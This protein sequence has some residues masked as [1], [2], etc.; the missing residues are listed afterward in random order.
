[1]KDET[2]KYVIKVLQDPTLTQTDEFKLWIQA[3]ENQELFL[4][5]KAALDNL[6]LDGLH[7]PVVQDEWER[8]KQSVKINIKEQ[9]ENGAQKLRMRQFLRWGAAAVFLLTVGCCS[10]FFIESYKLSDSVLL[11]KALPNQKDVVFCNNIGDKILL[12]PKDTIYK[13]KRT[14][15]VKE[16]YNT[17]QTP[18]GKDFKVTLSDGTEVTLNSESTLSYPADFRGNE[19]VVHLK[20]E[21]YFK[22]TKNAHKPFIVK[23]DYLQTKV[24]GTGFNVKA[25][26][27]SK[28]H[29]TLIEGSV[30]VKLNKN[31]AVVKLNPGEDVSLIND[32]TLN[33]ESVDTRR[34]T[35]WTNG[36]FFF[37]DASLEDIMREL[38]RWY[39]VN[40]EFVN[41]KAMNY[42]FNFWVD[43][44]KDIKE[45]LD[46]LHEINKVNFT[47]KDN[48]IT[49]T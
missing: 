31:N 47:F 7:L 40:V 42:H 11:V 22:V 33:V 6:L 28:P 36:Y 17:I 44:S 49:I 27:D 30:M 46:L 18:R 34:Y 48:T 20:G 10:Y 24:L 12:T 38:G 19:R 21:A 9:S 43:R 13:A 8:F 32:N 41:S 35:S 3:K 2:I 37:D 29:I 5:T 1:M 14:K 39:N 4:N 16:I 45:A 15:H 25:Y 23:T 26:P